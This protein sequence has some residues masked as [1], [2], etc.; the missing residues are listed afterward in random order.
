MTFALSYHP[1][2][3]ALLAQP[4]LFIGP[5]IP[6]YVSSGGNVMLPM[7][8]DGRMTDT[9]VP[10]GDLQGMEGFLKAHE[11][12][13]VSETPRLQLYHSE[14]FYEAAVR[15][16]WIRRVVD[17]VEGDWDRYRSVLAEHPMQNTALRVVKGQM[18]PLTLL[19]AA[20]LYLGPSGGQDSGPFFYPHDLALY[21]DPVD[22]RGNNL[23]PVLHFL[24]ALCLTHEQIRA[25][26]AEKIVVKRGR[27]GSTI[28]DLDLLGESHGPFVEF[29]LRQ[30]ALLALP[31]D[32]VRPTSIAEGDRHGN[33]DPTGLKG[34]HIPAAYLSL[35]TEILQR[36]S[37]FL[38]FVLLL[39]YQVDGC[40]ME[41]LLNRL[42]SVGQIGTLASREHRQFVLE[43]E[44]FELGFNLSRNEQGFEGACLLSALEALNGNN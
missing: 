42:K 31:R 19:V 4:R 17:W 41:A 43:S 7:T 35:Q 10:N 37:V 21:A 30:G 44:M 36:I 39:H 32:H 23:Y 15:P 40:L 13:F 9:G 11:D 1:N 26:V 16:A 6:G 33:V 24:E 8:L 2:V 14:A 12:R 20:S 27:A 34:V 3:P 38:G 29:A 22:T 5:E 18:A 28:H 25:G